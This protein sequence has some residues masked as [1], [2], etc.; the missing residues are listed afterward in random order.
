MTATDPRPQ[1]AAKLAARLA[2]A[3]EALV[4]AL[5]DSHIGLRWL[6]N[7][8]PRPSPRL[9]GRGDEKRNRP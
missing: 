3:A 8:C 9:G 7:A 4:L 6:R 2:P 5:P 1:L